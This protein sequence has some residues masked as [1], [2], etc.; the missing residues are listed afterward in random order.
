MNKQN[1][2]SLK[3]YKQMLANENDHKDVLDIEEQIFNLLLDIHIEQ[4]E[5]SCGP[6]TVKVPEV[7]ET[8]FKDYKREPAFDALLIDKIKYSICGSE[9]ATEEQAELINNLYV[10]F[11]SHYSYNEKLFGTDWQAECGRITKQHDNA[12]DE[13]KELK[14]YAKDLEKDYET[15]RLRATKQHD[16]ESNNIKELE[17]ENDRLKRNM[18][19]L[20]KIKHV[21]TV[22]PGAYIYQINGQPLEDY[23]EQHDKMKDQ[24][25]SQLTE[26]KQISNNVDH[27]QGKYTRLKDQFNIISNQHKVNKLIICDLEDKNKGL[28]HYANIGRVL[29]WYHTRCN[30]E[31]ILMY[32]GRFSRLRKFE[33]MFDHIQSLYRKDPENEAF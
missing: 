29:N 7:K 10:M 15:L 30:E 26:I 8:E 5:N 4:L 22:C 13:L 3:L 1:L 31:V 33:L 20:G 25:K 32:G 2:D 18:E 21:R 24:I 23:V 28:Q 11:E 27:W 14:Q 6:A 19:A 9:E 12:L 17:K 16:D